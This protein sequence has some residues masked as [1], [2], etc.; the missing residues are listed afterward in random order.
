MRVEFCQGIANMNL[1]HQKN[2]SSYCIPFLGLEEVLQPPRSLSSLYAELH[3]DAVV[4]I[5]DFFYIFLDTGN[6]VFL[7]TVL[8]G[9]MLIHS[10]LAQC[11]KVE[12]RMA[13]K[14]RSGKS[15][16]VSIKVL[17]VAF[18]PQ[19]SQ[20]AFRIR[21]KPGIS[22]RNATQNFLR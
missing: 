10:V 20:V 18:V 12:I 15:L 6:F 3:V 16:H 2:F 14:C 1:M 19:L 13:T 17:F 9:D 22:S 11:W 8:L 21:V 4:K 5:W 7:C